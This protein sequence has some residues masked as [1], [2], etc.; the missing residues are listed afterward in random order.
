MTESKLFE[1]GQSEFTREIFHL[2][3]LPKERISLLLLDANGNMLGNKRIDFGFSGAKTEED[4][5]RWTTEGYA[6]KS[7]GY[8]VGFNTEAAYELAKSN[9][10]TTIFIIHNHP[11]DIP[12]LYRN[13]RKFGEGEWANF[14][15]PS[16]TYNRNSD[17]V[18]VGLILAKGDTNTALHLDKFFSERGIDA[19][20]FIVAGVNQNRNGTDIVHN[21]PYLEFD[22][23]GVMEVYNVNSN[24]R[25]EILRNF[26]TRG[27]NYNRKIPY[28]H[29]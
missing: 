9:Q 8:G 3:C 6:D 12:G 15:A 16:G 28:L 7:M 27:G 18:P 22:S 19:R 21:P 2:S 13:D 23:S 17:Y 20:F 25:Y 10:A 1:L 29:T 5:K 24:Y 14:M 26:H 11:M 4:I